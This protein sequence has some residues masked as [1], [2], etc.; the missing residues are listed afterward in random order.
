MIFDYMTLKLIVWGF[1]G[2]FLIIFALTDGFDLGIGTL[3][4]FVAKNDTERRIVMNTIGPIWEG[5]QVWLITAGTSLF[6]AWPLAYATSFSAFYLVLFLLLW[7]L[8][9]R[10]VCFEYRSKLAHPKWRATWDWTLFIAS[11]VPV[12]VF[13][14]AFGNLLL[15]VAFHFN[16]I[17][18]KIIKNGQNEPTNP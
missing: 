14:A 3:L 18:K 10:P 7:T 15:G 4:P 17:P 6:A 9:L 11:T 2:L 13:G 12:I 5:Q 1:V 8:F 16:D